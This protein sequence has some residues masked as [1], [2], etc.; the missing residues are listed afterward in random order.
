[1]LSGAD[2]NWLEKVFEKAGSA[3]KKLAFTASLKLTPDWLAKK[4]I[5]TDTTGNVSDTE[6]TWVLSQLRRTMSGD[7]L[8]FKL[9]ICG[10]SGKTSYNVQLNL[11]DEGWIISRFD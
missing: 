10:G 6:G 9:D 5:Q 8:Q 4:G 3:P 11:G 1:M 7:V 2:Q